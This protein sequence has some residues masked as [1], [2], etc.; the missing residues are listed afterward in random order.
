M[1]C[2]SGHVRSRLKGNVVDKMCEDKHSIYINV[3]ELAIAA[4]HKGKR[5]EF[6]GYL[7]LFDSFRSLVCY[8]FGQTLDP[9]GLSS[10]CSALW[11]YRESKAG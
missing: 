10:F 5:V 7:V 8:E 3:Q 2:D 4:V 11:K 1:A 9:H 6:F